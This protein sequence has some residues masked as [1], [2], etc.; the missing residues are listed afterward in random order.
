MKRVDRANEIAESHEKY[1]KIKQAEMAEHIVQ[2]I[3]DDDEIRDE[4]KEKVRDEYEAW[5]DSYL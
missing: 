4:T 2:K 1:L 5:K 3:E